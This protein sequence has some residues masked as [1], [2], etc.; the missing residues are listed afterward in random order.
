M[1]NGETV[2]LDPDVLGE[3][4]LPETG[5]PSFAGVALA[6]GCALLGICLL[7]NRILR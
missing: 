7:L 6:S 1:V 3:E 4:E 2:I 5:G